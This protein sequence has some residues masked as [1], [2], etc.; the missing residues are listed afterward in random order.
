MRNQTNLQ[1]DQRQD[2]HRR[3]KRWQ[4][5]VSVLAAIVVFCTT[6]A[7]I[8]PAI[9]WE[10]QLICDAQEH[11]HGESCY[12]IVT[13]IESKELTCGKEE[14]LHDEACYEESVTLICGLEENEEHTHT[15]ECYQVEQIL[16]CTKEIHTHSDECFTIIPASEEK[17]LTCE[18]PEHTH[19]DAC[20]DA[21]P[22]SDEGV[23]CGFIEHTHNNYCYFSDGTLRCTIPEHQHTAE[24]ESDHSADV[25]TASDWMAT[26]EDV[27]LVGNWGKDVIAIAETQLGYNESTSNFILQGEN[28]KGYTRYG[29]WYGSPYGD[30]CAMFCSFCMNYAGISSDVMPREAYVPGWVEA[31]E[32]KDLYCEAR[33]Y[34]PRLGDL[35]FFDWE[36]YDPEVPESRDADHVGFVYALVPETEDSPALIRT[37]EGNSS[38]TVQVVTY[39]LDD[40]RI[41]GYGTM[42]ETISV[43]A[44]IVDGGIE[45]DGLCHVDGSYDWQWQVADDENKETWTD[46]P[47]ANDLSFV[48][49]PSED[50]LQG[51]YHLVGTSSLMMAS[52]APDLAAVPSAPSDPDYVPEMVVSDSVAPLAMATAPGSDTILMVAGSDFQDPK[53]SYTRSDYANNGDYSNQTARLQTVL[54]NIQDAYGDAYGFIAGGDYNFD[55]IKNSSSKTATGINAVKGA[56]ESVFG[57]D[58]ISVIVQGNH[59]ALN[60]GTSPTGA[61]DTEYYGVF[62]MNENEY[63]SYPK[64]SSKWSDYRDSESIAE[65]LASQLET[66]LAN[67]VQQNWNKPIFV[68]SHVPLHFSTRTASK[69]DAIYADYFYDVLY[70]YGDQ[71]NI[72]FLFGHDHAWGDDDYLG[73]ASVYLTD[74]DTINIAQH[75]SNSV[76]DVCPLNF[77]YM[78]Y[79]YTGYYWS[80]WASSSSQVKYSN[81]DSTLTMTAFLISGNS[82]VI[83]R[84]D[85]T[86]VHDLKSIG[87]AS[88]GYRGVS[89]VCPVT[90]NTYSSPQNVAGPGGSESTDPEQP[91]P[92]QPDIQTTEVPGGTGILSDWDGLSSAIAIT[93]GADYDLVASSIPADLPFTVYDIQKNEDA[94][95]PAEGVSVYLP[96]DDE[97]RVF[98]VENGA[99]VWHETELVVI[100]GHS[101]M[102]FTAHHFSIYGTAG[103]ESE[104][105]F[106]A[107]DMFTPEQGVTYWAKCTSTSDFTT[108]GTYMIVSGSQAFGVNGTGTG[109]SATAGSVTFTEIGTLDW[110]T[111]GTPFYKVSG[112]GA[113][114]L[115]TWKFSSTG[116]TYQLQN[117]GNTNRYLRISTNRNTTSIISDSASSLSLTE[118]NST[119]RINNGSYYLQYNSG[120]SRSTSTGN[121]NMTIY[122]K[123][124]VSPRV[125]TTS[126]FAVQK[127]VSEFNTLI[128]RSTEFYFVLK[129]SS[130]GS[131]SYDYT[132]ASPVSAFSYTVYDYAG[133]EV[134][135]RIT[136]ASTDPNL[137]KIAGR[138]HLRAGQTALFTDLDATKYYFVCEEISDDISSVGA[139]VNS[140]SKTV[141][142]DTNYSW[143][144]V[145]PSDF[146]TSQDG[147][148]QSFVKIT[149][150]PRE[151]IPTLDITLDVAGT[152]P[153]VPSDAVFNITV[154]PQGYDPSASDPGGISGPGGS[155]DLGSYEILEG[156]T[157][158]SSGT[159]YTIGTPIPLQSGQTLRISGLESGSYIIKESLG[160]YQDNVLGTIGALDSGISLNL[161]PD[162]NGDI[163]VIVAHTGHSGISLT[164]KL[165]GVHEVTF[166]YGDGQTIV[167][168]TDIDGHIAAPWP[169]KQRTGMEFQGWRTT[170]DVAGHDIT[171]SEQ[172][173]YTFTADTTLYAH[174]VGFPTVFGSDAEM[175]KTFD[176]NTAYDTDVNIENTFDITLD[177]YLPSSQ[178]MGVVLVL[179]LSSSMKTMCLK[180]GKY[181][182]E[183]SQSNHACGTSSNV[184]HYDGTQSSIDND[185][186]TGGVSHTFVKRLDVARQEE[187]K[188]LQNLAANSYDKDCYVQLVMFDKTL[189][190]HNE[191]ALNIGH[192]N[193]D[194]TNAANLQTL[195]NAVN[196]TESDSG[197]NIALGLY[198]AYQD[199]QNMT[200]PVA[201]GGLGLRGQDTYVVLLSDG[202]PTTNDQSTNYDYMTDDLGPSETFLDPDFIYKWYADPSN[203]THWSQYAHFDFGKDSEG[204]VYDYDEIISSWNDFTAYDLTGVDLTGVTGV[205]SSSLVAGSGSSS[206][207]VF[208]PGMI[209]ATPYYADM[210]RDMGSKFYSVMFGVNQ[211]NK[212]RATADNWK[213]VSGIGIDNQTY[214]ASFSDY[215]AFASSAQELE[216]FYDTVTQ[217]VVVSCSD[218]EIT[219]PMSNHVE[220]LYFTD[221]NGDP[222]ASDAVLFPDS[223]TDYLYRY[224]PDSRTIYWYPAESGKLT[225][226]VRLKNEA[227]GFADW[228]DSGGTSYPTNGLTSFSYNIKAGANPVEHKYK[229]IDV[230]YAHGWLGELTFTKYGGVSPENGE[231]LVG[232][233]FELT[234]DPNCPYCSGIGDDLSE[235]T[236]RNGTIYSGQLADIE[237]LT[238]VSS[239]TGEVT[240]P[241]V[242]SGHTYILEETETPG[243]QYAP[244]VP[245]HVT[246]AYD[247]TEEEEVVS[248]VP[249][250]DDSGYWDVDGSGGYTLFDLSTGGVELPET[251]GIGTIPFDALGTLLIA[252]SALMFGSAQRRK[253]EERRNC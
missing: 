134:E 83:T 36:D 195:I 246:V 150:I 76:Y 145:V 154:I 30:W 100:D 153:D 108:S 168:F 240:F 237:P 87:A 250:A 203:P 182:E 13:T 15:D 85:E 107:P 228:T 251:G 214:I 63:R 211:D 73:G 74:G 51:T 155:S 56:V 235:V 227:S 172:L 136:D 29:A 212:S 55:E 215:S 95:V 127:L 61:N 177:C 16:I 163:Q 133:N 41:L 54:G 37:I 179:D 149:N 31:L 131:A 190:Y 170:K 148:K 173:T 27:E 247:E 105:E 202:A 92:D 70:E 25:E 160:E 21:P 253:R 39:A 3:K 67:K 47:G 11:T 8:L 186:Q 126:Q 116:S 91:G 161:A 7:L 229:T 81:A 94:D 22:A 207:K 78:N 236:A 65:T 1:L 230:P 129:S 226:K 72:I 143:V 234:H 49:D 238:A 191:T 221:E 135:T 124:T 156:S 220:F 165:Q 84:W 189:K 52:A 71:L 122:K 24:C 130:S 194:A 132:D 79:G 184:T 152:D 245:Y 197:T 33:E 183:R 118:N 166:D 99:L 216:E 192:S 178:S 93:A 188:F 111:D 252:V 176:E 217:S 101:Y 157:V 199:I 68:V 119:W 219:D 159:S 175:S 50:D 14:H 144:S 206:N 185:E 44:E 232:A 82:V 210:I 62:V 53:T 114:N 2:A 239:D 9:K 20:F 110:T 162:Q 48:L 6:Y 222:L 32:E 248:V 180:C 18:I 66:Y 5:I 241:Y 43:S 58:I 115:F 69:N 102:L 233:V 151:D 243:D 26:F 231:P 64:D 209:L 109:A 169:S 77:T 140:V 96:V 88:Q 249:T 98:G 112:D 60:S 146:T 187:V 139:T 113:T 38:N 23:Y 141:T 224:D 158:V 213:Y 120:F 137:G 164:N 244:C 10:R 125:I 17:V 242:P 4:R 97:M 138:F 59:D 42:P 117:A 123:V 223:Q 34:E 12:T 193:T 201:N 45:L 80:Q 198:T 75:G 106:P 128:D 208:K 121:A 90:T 57:D 142:S 104:F 171:S 147:V 86:G 89:E 200:I 40:D 205:S 19:T 181:V 218:V 46:I 174:W 103:L 225:Y 167:R 196:G 28:R 204:Y 35:I